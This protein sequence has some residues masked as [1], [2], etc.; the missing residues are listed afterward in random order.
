MPVTTM[1]RQYS[2]F[3]AKWKR[4]RDA[5]SGSDAVK[6]AGEAY[7]PRLG[8]Q[9]DLEYKA[10]KTRA[11][12]Y[13][14]TKRTVQGLSG[15]VMRKEPAITLKNE[16][17]KQDLENVTLNG[18]SLSAFAKT[19]I[20]ETLQVGRCGVL[21]DMSD[22]AAIPASERRPYWSFYAAEAIKNWHTEIRG[23]VPVLV[24]VVL[25]EESEQQKGADEFE[26]ECK[27]QYRVLR[28]NAEGNYEVQ[29]Y[30]KAAGAEATKEGEWIPGPVT[31]PQRRGAPLKY[32]PFVF[33]NPTSV[34][35][36]IEDPP[37][38]DLVDVNLSHYLTSADLEHGRH[39]CGLP[40]VWATGIPADTKMKVGSSVVLTSSDPN[41]RFG[42]LEFTGKG[43]GALETGTESKERQMAVLG[44]RLLEQQ[45]P[46]VESND[47]I[48]TRTAGE[49]SILQ[50]LCQ[51]IGQALT[52]VLRWHAD[53]KGDTVDDEMVIALNQDFVNAEMPTDLLLALLQAVQ[54]GQISWET[55][56]FNLEKGEITRPGVDAETEKALIEEQNS[57][58]GLLD[59]E[60]EA[61]VNA[62]LAQK[63][64]GQMP[65][66]KQSPA[67]P[68]KKPAEQVA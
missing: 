10:Y 50:S 47:T 45:K 13:G 17:L 30:T 37:L 48:V 9:T 43:L 32:I 46:A 1:H 38:I 25:Y 58:N 2:A 21:C 6:D 29:V 57:S 62:A 15:A 27:P 68:E 31:I 44:A 49:R 51:T 66:G 24:K 55:F 36:E 52:Q 60:V 12:W 54:S 28:L 3:A 53:W 8:D 40:T 4:C 41:A 26:Y 19:V 23:G 39:F 56:Y 61:M 64:K 34:T 20:E 5:Y 63:R 22:D 14:A 65:N 42:I 33:I 67:Q 16:E 18:V 7:L 59:Q 35:P 11:L